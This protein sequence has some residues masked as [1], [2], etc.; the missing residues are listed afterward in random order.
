MLL[1]QQLLRTE[2]YA[3]LPVEAASRAGAMERQVIIVI[4]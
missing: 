3:I 2:I 4:H 1:D